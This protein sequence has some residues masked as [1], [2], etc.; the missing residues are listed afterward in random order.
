[1]AN[2]FTNFL[3]QTLTTDTQMKDYQHASRLYVDDYFR[4]APKAGF[5]YYVVFNINTNK[6]PIIEQFK[7]KNGRELGLLVKTVDLPKYRIATE[8]VNQYNKKTIIQSKIEYQPVSMA[9]HDDHNNTTIGMWKAYYNYY[10]VDG[11]NVSGLLI[12][13]SYGNTKYKKNGAVIEE[14]TAYGMNNG[15]TDPFFKSIEIYQ[16]N[17]KQFTAF[18][19][20]N[21]VITDFNHDKLD[22]SQ[23]KFLENN[24]T[25][26][27]ET[28]LYG[29]GQIK[30][31]NP[32]GY[33]TI[34]YDNTPGPLSVFG[35]GNNSIFGPGGIIPGI[36]EVLGGAG[37]QTPLGLFKTARGAAALAKN[38]K[39]VS[40]ASLLSEGYG[41]LD[42]VARTG[43][44]P[45]VLSGSSPAGITLATLPGELG[46]T[47]TPR[48]QQA[49][50]AGFDLGGIAGGIAAG[51]GGAI[52]GLTDRIGG[53]IRG[54]LPANLANASLSE[55]GN[56]RSISSE[57]SFSFEDQIT[58]Y[59]GLKEELDAR[60]A[61]ADG[62]Q[63]TLDNIYSEFDEL[64]YTDP[65][66]LQ[67][68]YE[69]V[70]SD[71][72]GLD[73]LYNE[74]EEAETPDSTLSVEN[75][76]ETTEGNINVFN[77]TEDLQP[78]VTNFKGQQIISNERIIQEREAKELELI[79]KL[80]DGPYAFSNVRA[81]R[82]EFRRL[83][84]DPT[85]NPADVKAARDKY[86]EL[87]AVRDDLNNEQQKNYRLLED[88]RDAKL[89]LPPG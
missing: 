52:G 80:N 61:A 1:M 24:M 40:K 3:K 59:E 77:Q 7:S 34:H 69:S 57:L 6:N 15:Q 53:A 31:D 28:V 51:I 78:S 11:K 70:Q 8:T 27:Y 33:A 26:Q 64:N 48:S 32:A 19:L 60:V 21:P 50:G 68:S 10:F 43:K 37:D 23:S 47:A 86:E 5:L 87:Q 75:V 18:I 20:V 85:A 9:F 45:S 14:S 2:A 54:I 56:T 42:K 62:D 16:L 41:I 88:A 17:R 35:G 44:L 76:E 67:V 65:E 22:Q 25:I 49:G 82:S 74:A 71:L 38:V 39:N 73:E 58:E 4:L 81:A 63:E 66:K 29:T 72:E 55:I 13:S 83:N 36:G 89:R 79:S 84:E 12:P 46:T 30:K